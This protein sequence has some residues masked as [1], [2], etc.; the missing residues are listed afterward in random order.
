[1]NYKC[2]LIE[3]T[4]R[5]KIYLRRYGRD[6]DK[7]CPG[8]YGYH[9]ADAYIGEGVENKNA[10]G[11]ITAPPVSDY[12]DD[13]RW[14]AACPCGYVFTADDNIQV[15]TQSIYKR[16]D[17]G[18]E[19]TL[20]EAPVGAMWNAWW[21]VGFQQGP[22]GKCLIVRMPGD[23][24]WTVDGRASNC[25][26]KCVT[27]GQP[28]SAHKDLKREQCAGFTDSRPHQCWIRH[29]AAPLLTVDKAGVT[30]GAGAGSIL[31]PGWHGF[32]RNGVL[33]QC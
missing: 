10:E 16:V 7:K 18:E 20:K 25:D 17:T 2:F 21:C 32:L 14:P 13:P 22:D 15:F 1:M 30:C 29:G 11:H 3:E 27:C 12:K 26:S 31:V 33:E 5:Q 23:H 8:R 19:M 6:D 24:D 9:N 28:Y 4:G